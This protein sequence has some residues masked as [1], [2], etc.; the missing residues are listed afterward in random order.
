MHRPRWGHGRIPVGIVAAVLLG[1]APVG[2]AGPGSESTPARSATTSAPAP[3]ARPGPQTRPNVVVI[4][5]DDQR[6]DSLWAMKNVR[7]LLSRRGTTFQNSFATTAQ[8]CPSRATFLTGQLSH[9]H[10]VLSN[11]PPDGGYE[12][13]DHRETLPVWLL[14]SGYRTIFLGKYLNGYGKHAPAI[15]PGWNEWQ[16]FKS[17]DYLDYELNRNGR[18]VSYGTEPA[19]YSTD[20]LSRLAVG[21]I[22]RAAPKT[23]PFF[24][25][26]NTKAPHVETEKEDTARGMPIP[27]PRHRAVFGRTPL[28]RPSSFNEADVSD[29]PAALRRSPLGVQEIQTQTTRYRR[30]L[31]SLASVDDLVGAVVRALQRNR[32]LA[33]TVIVYT[34]DNGFLFGEHR[35]ESKGL[36]Y[37]P[38]I[39]VPLVIRG[40]GFR[41]G[42]RR[43]DLVANVDLAATILALARATPGRSQDGRSLLGPADPNRALLIEDLGGEADERFIAIRTRGWLL[44]EYRGGEEEL[45]SLRADPHQLRNLAG[46]ARHTSVRAAL[47]QELARLRGCAGAS[48]RAS[49]PAAAR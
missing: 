34:S 27:A 10:K 42:A 1:A 38:S 7:L 31:Q 43:T 28:P 6:A 3:P 18:L 11:G 47:K 25:W 41:A 36:P 2:L 8:C 15:P 44:V 49:A 23:T 22:N 26:L 12:A 5:T 30:T 33:R 46:G 16:A 40:P 4:E 35:L 32:E 21:T 14:R 39:R 13:L 37:E 9:N 48:C 20:V 19:A 17:P 24:I 29:K 45:Y